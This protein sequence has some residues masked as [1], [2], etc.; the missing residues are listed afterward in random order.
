MPGA[1]ELEGIIIPEDRE[2]GNE[3][4]RVILNQD[5]SNQRI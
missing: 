5:N 3:S 4:I 1:G 2:R